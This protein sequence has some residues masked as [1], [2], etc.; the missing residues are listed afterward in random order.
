MKRYLLASALEGI[1]SQKL[2]RRLCP[3]CR[4][5]RPTTHYEKELFQKVLHKEVNEIYSAEG[6]E[7]CGTG[8]KGRIALHEV[9]LINQEIRDALSEGMPKEKLRELVYKADVAT[10]LQDGLKK[11]EAGYTTFEEVLKL[12]ELD[13]DDLAGENDLR[14]A[15][16]TARIAL[17]E[18]EDAQ[19]P[20]VAPQAQTTGPTPNVSAPSRIENRQIENAV[21]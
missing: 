11:V 3:H 2:A 18:K 1:I 14:S 9:L 17:S 15:I 6:C 5:K 8:Y 21:E 20:N 12:I 4:T 19:K 10:L 16:D 13:D 7:Q